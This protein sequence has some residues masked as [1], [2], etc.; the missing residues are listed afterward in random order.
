MSIM[1]LDLS[2]NGFHY[3]GCRALAKALSHNYTLRRLD[4]TSNRIDKLCLNELLKGLQKNETL[5]S[6]QV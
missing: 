3:D 6:I 5:M 4:L 1:N 2:W